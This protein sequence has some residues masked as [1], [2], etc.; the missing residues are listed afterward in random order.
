MAFG[1]FPYI[2]RLVT[3]QGKWRECDPNILASDTV[4]QAKRQEHLT[5]CTWAAAKEAVF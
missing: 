2:K 5:N 1:G 4:K 3:F